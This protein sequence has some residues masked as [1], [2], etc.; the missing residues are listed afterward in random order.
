[1]QE[2]K[3]LTH[4]LDWTSDFIF[5]SE[6]TSFLEKKKICLYLSVYLPAIRQE[7]ATDRRPF[8]FLLLMTNSTA[9]KQ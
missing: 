5:K 3:T 2:D 7:A 4:E 6:L 1:M 9:Q 8:F